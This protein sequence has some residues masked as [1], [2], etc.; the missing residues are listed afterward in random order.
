M[1]IDEKIKL[2]HELFDNKYSL[3]VYKKFDKLYPFTTENINGY[4]NLF[5]L[6]GKSLL[7]V[8]SSSDQVFNAVLTGCNEISVFDI[9]PFTQEYF[10]L[11]K[12]ALKVLNREEYL[13]FFH[14]NKINNFFFSINTY[15]ALREEI[16]EKNP[17]ACYFWDE[18]FI[19]Y[20]NGRII[21][22]KIFSDD[23]YKREVLEKINLYLKNDEYYNQLGNKIDKINIDFEIGNIFDYN[24]KRLYDNIW[25]SNIAT[26]HK[27]SDV[28]KLFLNLFINIADNGKILIAYLYDTDMEEQC[29]NGKEDIYN[30]YATLDL[31]PKETV[32][33][34]FVGISGYR[35][36]D[37]RMK[38][39]VLTYTKKR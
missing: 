7:T 15:M 19:K 31:L 12:A 24:S 35:V 28:S 18:L 20:K 2:A 5:D 8:G 11:K 26:Y 38:D 17:E 25:L 22:D 36:G 4:T 29:Y 9:C 16:K 13:T 39:S 32:L 10:D 33:D 37:S 14:R 34:S 6:D 23:E 1:D 3:D 27:L 21:R 30:I